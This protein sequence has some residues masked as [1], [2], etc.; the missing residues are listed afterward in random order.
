MPEEIQNPFKIGGLC[1]GHSN[2]SCSVNTKLSMNFSSHV[3]CKKK[4]LTSLL[5]N[6]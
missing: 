4:S 3:L 6:D 5:L 2:C 1:A